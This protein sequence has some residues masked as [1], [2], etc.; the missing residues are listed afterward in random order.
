MTFKDNLIKAR[1]YIVFILG[2]VVA[3]SAVI[4]I[5]FK[6]G[7][8]MAPSG[9]ILTA[10][11]DRAAVRTARP[12]NERELEWAKVAW[13][14]F[15]RNMDNAT[16]L[17]GSVENYPSA[18]MWDIGSYLL[19][20][21]SAQQLK[22]I[23]DAEF[24]RRIDTA[25]VSLSKLELFDKQ[26]PNKAYNIN[27]LKMTDYTNKPSARGVGWSV[28]DVGRVLVPL[29]V[30]VWHYPQHT[31]AARKVIGSWN[32]ANLSKHGELQGA[33]VDKA[34]KTELVQEGRLGYEQYASKTFSLMGVDVTS[35]GNYT[36]QMA[37]VDVYGI[38]VAHDRRIPRLFGAQNFVIS[39]PYVLD[40]LEFGWD[41]ASRELAWR[42]YAAQQRRFERTGVLTAVTE[43]HIDQKPYFV[44]NTVFS[45][46]KVWNAITEEG[47]DASAH[48]TL[49]VKAA[50]GWYALFG[51][52]YSTKLVEAVSKLHD[53]ERGWYGGQY[54]ANGKPN[55]AI[56]ANTNAVVLES[57]AYIERGPFV[58]YQ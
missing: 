45:D 39:E 9:P 26:L 51:D 12:L 49:S 6:S 4:W 56:T 34:G 52:A 43:D 40:G 7:Y 16:G 30:L 14:Y 21:I 35:S 28:I 10:S 32:V 38:K 13:K 44:Y 47:H 25:L 53:V 42:V 27:T 15:E 1:S 29:N 33:R 17:P 57:L 55:K 31:T 22:L 50:F 3:F 5:E 36:R 46:G 37:H 11:V 2:L 54:E 19:A 20:V 8:G 58:R 24:D 41:S 48:R 18:T 23:D